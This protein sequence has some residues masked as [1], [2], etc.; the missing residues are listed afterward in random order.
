MVFGVCGLGTYAWMCAVVPPIARSAKAVFVR[1]TATAWSAALLAA[2][3][4]LLWTM[5]GL[6]TLFLWTSNEPRAGLIMF[7]T[8]LGLFGVAAGVA[9]WIIHAIVSRGLPRIG[10][11]FETA[12]ALSIVAV[13]RDDPDTLDRVEQLYRAYAAPGNADPRA[14]QLAPGR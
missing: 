5:V 12:T 7:G 6:A 14:V 10:Q 8:R 2:G 11:A 1:P 4:G 9:S 3:A 13:V